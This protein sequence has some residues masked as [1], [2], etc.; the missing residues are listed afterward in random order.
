MKSK[1]CLRASNSTHRTLQSRAT[2]IHQK[3]KKALTGLRTTVVLLVVEIALGISII[4]V[5]KGWLSWAVPLLGPFHHLSP[6]VFVVF[7]SIYSG[8]YIGMSLSLL[9]LGKL[10]SSWLEDKSL[11]QATDSVSKIPVRSS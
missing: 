9:D 2:N 5:N 7:D 11:R 4:V 3:S 1:K 10:S 8:F 6:S